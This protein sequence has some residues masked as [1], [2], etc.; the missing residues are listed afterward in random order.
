MTRVFVVVS[1][2]IDFLCEAGKKNEEYLRFVRVLV[3][4][5]FI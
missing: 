4:G 2:K 5:G 1:A 3:S